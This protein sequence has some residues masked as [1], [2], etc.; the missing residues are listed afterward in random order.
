MAKEEKKYEYNIGTYEIVYRKFI[1]SLLNEYDIDY[2]EEWVSK[3]DDY[4]R[5]HYEP[6]STVGFMYNVQVNGEPN[7][8]NFIDYLIKQH[9]KNIEKLNKLIKETKEDK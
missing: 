7:V 2:Q 3:Y 4:I 5:L 9:I 8:V 1:L 6:I